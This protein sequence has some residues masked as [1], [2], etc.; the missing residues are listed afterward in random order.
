MTGFT[1]LKNVPSDGA[2]AW[3][4][5]AA[6]LT[7]IGNSASRG[8]GIGTNGNLI[9]GTPDP[10]PSAETGNLTVKKEVAGT[11]QETDM[12]FSIQ[13]TLKKDDETVADIT[14]EYGEMTFTNGVATVA[15]KA[16]QSITATGLPTDITYE[17]EETAESR[18]GYKVTYTNQTGKIEKNTT[19]VATVTNTTD[20][21]DPTPETGSLTVSKSVSGSGASTS[22]EFSFNIHFTGKELADSYSYTMTGV[23]GSTETGNL[24]LAD[25]VGLFKL[26]HGQ[27]I[28]VTGLP[29]GTQFEIIESD[30]NGYTATSQFGTTTSGDSIKGTIEADHTAKVIFNN[31]KGGGG[32]PSDSYISVSVKKVW[33]LDDGGT[34]SDSVTMALLKDGEQ[35]DTATLSESNRW[36]YTWS[37]LN[38]HYIWT[39]EEVDV[40]DGF[41]MS[42]SQSGNTFTIINDDVPDTP[43]NP[44][45]PDEPD[46]P[47]VPDYPD[48]PSMQD[49]PDPPDTPGGLSTTEEPVLPRTG[50]LWWPAVLTLVLGLALLTS[51]VL[52]MHR[53]RYH[54][55]Y[56]M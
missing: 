24:S 9:I 42:V 43:D 7:I 36:S 33:K 13:V 4:E 29:A 25:G 48:E 56:E 31:Y 32:G 53:R 51:G 15:L 52:D 28:T 16:G 39:V 26:K 55:K 49:H 54:G 1:A 50:Q 37:G 30:N 45:Y 46:V 2:K 23:D 6:K 12:E 5:A 34:A 20:V 3:A 47:G 10:D 40:P 38:D 19:V 27:T 18:D 44:D 14:G 17:V 11:D 21:P 22:K 41:T 8:G 35:Y